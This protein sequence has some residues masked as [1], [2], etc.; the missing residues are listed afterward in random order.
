MSYPLGAG[1][2]S[3][4]ILRK[5]GAEEQRSLVLKVHFFEVTFSFP[6][7][8]ESVVPGEAT[9]DC[10]RPFALESVAVLPLS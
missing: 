4:R 10:F 9:D 3:A 1:V 5:I 6:L 8:V 7:C 2:N